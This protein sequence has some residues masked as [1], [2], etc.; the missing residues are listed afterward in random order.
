MQYKIQLESTLSPLSM[1]LT[2]MREANAL[3]SPAAS[4]NQEA[5]IIIFLTSEIF[6]LSLWHI[7]AKQI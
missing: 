4:P 5:K 2:G 7:H 3:K 1:K 6:L